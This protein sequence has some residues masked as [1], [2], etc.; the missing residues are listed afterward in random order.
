MPTCISPVE[1]EQRLAPLAETL[2]QRFPDLLI[3]VDPGTIWLRT[4]TCGGQ[5][6]LRFSVEEEE[7]SLH[8]VCEFSN[9]MALCGPMEEVKVG[10]CDYQRVYDALEIAAQ[11]FAD[12]VV[13]RGPS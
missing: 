5:V 11:A 9:G 10:I 7:L 1:Y 2:R 6:S 3:S 13:T 8:V 4:K 12:V